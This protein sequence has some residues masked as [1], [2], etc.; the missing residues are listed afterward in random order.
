MA[1]G[2][3]RGLKYP[4]TV[5]QDSK[6]RIY[7]ESFAYAPG[8]FRFNWHRTLE[9]L[10]LLRGRLSAYV[11][12]SALNMEED[13]ILLIN[14]N[15]GHATL[16]TQPDTVLLLLHL[17]PVVFAAQFSQEMIPCFFCRSTAENRYLASAS[18]LRRIM[19]ELYVQLWLEELPAAS[20]G[21]AGAVLS[22]CA[23][24]LQRFPW[25]PVSLQRQGGDVEKARQILRYVDQNYAQR[26]R[27]EDVAQYMG[28]N[29]T[30][31]STFFKE[32]IGVN[33]FDYLTR[34]RLAQAGQLL[35]NSKDSVL[36]IA[37]SSGFSDVKSFNAAFRKF[38]GLSP[39]RYRRQLGHDFPQ[40]AREAM[41]FLLPPE[42]P[43]V[44]EKLAAYRNL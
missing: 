44:E 14:S 29:R 2:I 24:L 8:F 27:L 1:E 3:H 38:Y 4:G 32:Q 30:Y 28:M 7:L 31:L 19:A 17:D 37:L 6:N 34:K 10:V 20:L 43:A 26:L 33:F 11:E 35:N 15:A 12:G 39:D 16:A 21:A 41:P 36:S 40:H 42:H 23:L 9:I 22:L 18:A 5:F 13:D 25:E